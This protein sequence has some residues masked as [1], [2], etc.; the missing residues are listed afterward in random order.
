MVQTT[1]SYYLFRSGSDVNAIRMRNAPASAFS[2]AFNISY[3]RRSAD[4]PRLPE[5]KLRAR[6]RISFKTA[7]SARFCV[8]EAKFDRVI[9]GDQVAVA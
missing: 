9:S 7:L 3:F 2:E 6:R 4:D 5:Y 1:M 8:G